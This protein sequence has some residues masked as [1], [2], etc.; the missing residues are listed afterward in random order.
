MTGSPLVSIGIITYNQAAFIEETLTSALEQDYDNLEVVVAD[1]AS[2]DGTAA[3][4]AEFERRYPGRLKPLLHEENVGIAGNCNRM[5][6]ACRGQYVAFQ[7]GDDVLLPGKIARQVAWLEADPSRVLCGHDVEIFEWPSGRVLGLWSGRMPLRSGQGPSRVIQAGCPY[8][9][10]SVM[11]RATALPPGGYD[12]RLG[13]SSE[14]KLWIDCLAKGGHFGY[15]EGVYAR[16]RRHANNVT[17]IAFSNPRRLRTILAENLM[18]LGQVEAEQPWLRSQCRA[19]R[20]LHTYACGLSF[21][22]QGDGA[23]AR[24]FLL[25]SLSHRLTFS[26]K[27]Y[28]ALM[29][30]LPPQRALNPLLARVA[31]RYGL[32]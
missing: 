32:T 19:G 22:L 17:S 10:T 27:V 2:T 9:A 1:D 26:W 13:W 16:Y 12:E 8:S 15:I 25:S 4:I 7:G 24:A 11:V 23:T 30:S 31:A 14:W 18:T 5:L 6:R 20:A 29:L 3:A 21:L 28:A